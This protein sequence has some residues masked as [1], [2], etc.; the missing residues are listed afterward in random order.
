ME[1]PLFTG[2]DPEAWV[3]RAELCFNHLRLSDVG[4][5]LEAHFSMDGRAAYWLKWIEERRNF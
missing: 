5:L 4:K 2:K 1:L 3:L